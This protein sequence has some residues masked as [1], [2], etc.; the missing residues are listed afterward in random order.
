MLDVDDGAEFSFSS[1]SLADDTDG[2]R[3]SF[4]SFSATDV[5]AR[6]EASST[7]ADIRRAG[8]ALIV[9]GV[10]RELDGIRVGVALTVAL[11]E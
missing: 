8:G 6:F 4:C 10:P 7:D 9:L 5:D 1:G 11:A 3:S 2:R